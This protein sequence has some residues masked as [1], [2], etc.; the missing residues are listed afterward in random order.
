MFTWRMIW[1]NGFRSGDKV[2]ECIGIAKEMTISLKQQ[3]FSGMM[4]STIGW[5]DRLPDVL[6]TMVG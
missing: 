6:G 2:R 3:G 1:S 5:E 4:I